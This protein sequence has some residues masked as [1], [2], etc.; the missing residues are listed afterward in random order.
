MS[1]WLLRETAANARRPRRIINTMLNSRAAKSAIAPSAVRKA[2][3][4]PT[5]PSAKSG[6][7]SLRS[8]LVPALSCQP[9]RPIKDENQRSKRNKE[10][11]PM[12][13]GLPH[14]SGR[15]ACRSLKSSTVLGLSRPGPA[16]VPRCVTAW[17]TLRAMP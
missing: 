2:C 5:R 15:R 8:L 4:I 6:S 11:Q 16:G 7:Q 9:S 12:F 14:R 13:N 10:T 3:L 17:T 1:T